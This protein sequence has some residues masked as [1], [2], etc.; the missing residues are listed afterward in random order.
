MESYLT[1]SDEFIFDSLLKTIRF[2]ITLSISTIATTLALLNV[3]NV[4]SINSNLLTLA[5][6]ILMVAIILSVLGQLVLT[7]HIAKKAPANI[8]DI[9]LYLTG[10]WLCYVS[11]VS[12]IL[13]NIAKSIPKL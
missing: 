8:S 4:I 13:Y 1:I 6:F 10:F 5:V 3:T 7:G 11:G 2:N 12:L 9:K